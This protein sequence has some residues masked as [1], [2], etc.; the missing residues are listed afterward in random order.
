MKLLVS[1]ISVIPLNLTGR[2]VTTKANLSLPSLAG[3]GRENMTKDLQ[4]TKG[5]GEITHQLL[6]SQ[7]RLS[8]GKRV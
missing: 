1:S 4:S 3:Q 8:L 7:N 2:Q 5:Q 6:P